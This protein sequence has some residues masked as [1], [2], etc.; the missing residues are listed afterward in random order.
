M[1][2]YLDKFLTNYL[3]KK[4][5]IPILIFIHTERNQRQRGF[6]VNKVKLLPIFPISKSGRVSIHYLP[7]HHYLL[8]LNQSIRFQSAEVKSA[9]HILYILNDRMI[10]LLYFT[11]I[12]FLAATCSLIVKSLLYG[13]LFW[14]I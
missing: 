4:L 12:M 3:Y 8:C 10:P 1:H 2:L 11:S 14:F 6:F 7:H 5:A 13:T 9:G